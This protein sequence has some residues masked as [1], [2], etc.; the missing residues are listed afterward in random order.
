LDQSNKSVANLLDSV[1]LKLEEIKTQEDLKAQLKKQSET[2]KND[3]NAAMNKGD[4]AHALEKYTESIKTDPSNLA[5]RSNRVLAFLKLKRFL[6]AINDATIVVDSSDPSETIKRKAI[7]RR[8][9]AFYN[10]AIEI[11]LNHVEAGKLLTL[12]EKDLSRLHQ[13]EPSEAVFDLLNL[14]KSSLETIR[15]SKSVDKSQ[16]SDKA[17]DNVANPIESSPKSSKNNVPLSPSPTKQL[18]N[19]SQKPNVPEEPPKTLYE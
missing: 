11:T 7:F 16:S 4:F 2:L 15:V 12:A 6:D 8:S 18:K 5:A 13:V 3:G 17:N 14:V 9:E 1:R 19:I 10:R